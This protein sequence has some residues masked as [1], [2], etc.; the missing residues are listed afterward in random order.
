MLKIFIKIYTKICHLNL[1]SYCLIYSHHHFRI[2]YSSFSLKIEKKLDNFLK[3][4]TINSNLEYI[5]IKY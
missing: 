1:E 3:I 5:V 4:L 2:Q